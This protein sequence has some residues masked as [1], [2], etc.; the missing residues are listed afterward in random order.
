M[1]KKILDRYNSC[2]G[3]HSYSKKFKRHLTERINDW[4]ERRKIR[5]LL[6]RISN[7]KPFLLT[8]D[9]PCGYGRLFPIVQACSQQVV[10]ADWSFHLLSLARKNQLLDSAA[11]HPAHVRATAF[12]LPFHNGIFDMVLS[13]RLCHHIRD[14][15]E[16]LRYVLELLRVSR[17]WVVFTFFD[18]DSFKNR[19]RGWSQRFGKKRSK[20]TLTT[21]EIV[22][23]ADQAGFEMAFS[24][25]L[26]RL[27]S[28][29]RYIVLKRRG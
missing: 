5:W 2:E 16:R 17:K 23:L 10:E 27:F 15:A 1:D 19:M 14:H 9:L 4:N 18:S 7:G 22:S 20:W 25:P 29:H 24:V 12:S 11:N 3:A 28:G 13:V 6:E 21:S 26:S 8:L